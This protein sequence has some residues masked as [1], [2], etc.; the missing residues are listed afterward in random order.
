MFTGVIKQIEDKKYDEAVANLKP[1]SSSGDDEIKAKANY[2]LGYI[3]TRWD[4][5]WTPRSS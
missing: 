5:K 3:N 1:L 4:Y 2:L